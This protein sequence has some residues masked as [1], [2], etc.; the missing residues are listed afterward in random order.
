MHA[1]LPLYVVG[2]YRGIYIYTS[3]YAVVAKTVLCMYYNNIGRLGYNNYTLDKESIIDAK[4]L[5]ARLCMYVGK[6]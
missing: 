5:C 2:L 1:P 4:I 6:L 3:V